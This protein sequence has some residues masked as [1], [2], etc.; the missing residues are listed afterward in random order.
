MGYYSSHP[1]IQ[2]SA[3]DSCSVP[4]VPRG[5]LSRG[6]RGWRGGLGKTTFAPKFSWTLR[7][8]DFSGEVTCHRCAGFKQQDFAQRLWAASGATG[9]KKQKGGSW[10]G[11]RQVRE[12]LA[13]A[14]RELDAGR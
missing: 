6:C 12:Q 5:T 14:L 11:F 3:K 9:E 2:P 4:L 8:S 13:P 10:E 7:E 1:T